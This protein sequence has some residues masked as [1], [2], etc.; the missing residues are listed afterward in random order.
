MASN[1]SLK[2]L[3][4]KAFEPL[5]AFAERVDA[6]MEK[7]QLAPALAGASTAGA[8]TAGAAAFK[9]ATTSSLSLT[10]LAEPPAP[11]RSARTD[12]FESARKQG[13]TAASAAQRGRSQLAQSASSLPGTAATGMTTGGAPGAT[14]LVEGPGGEFFKLPA[15]T[16]FNAQ[17]ST[18]AP[19]AA[20]VV[21]RMGATLEMRSDGAV[22]IRDDGGRPYLSGKVVGVEPDGRVVSLTVNYTL[23]GQVGQGTLFLGFT[24]G[25]L[26]YLSGSG[27]GVDEAGRT[28][29][30]DL[31]VV[32]GRPAAAARPASGTR[33]IG[34]PGAG[35]KAGRAQVPGRR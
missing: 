11:S 30:R 23:N 8:A 22:D 29:V 17:M 4:E 1:M 32:V 25:R 27:T 13:M 16:R 26:T 35:P 10:G 12:T 24:D 34:K 33:A 9:R 7:R 18:Q 19:D 31:G 3:L 5:R 2:A 15:S 20:P 6:Q 21:S 28:V 14:V